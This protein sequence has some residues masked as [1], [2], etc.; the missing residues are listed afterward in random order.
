VLLV[1]AGAA[2][3]ASARF[4]RLSVEDGLSQ[5]S[6]ESIAEDRYGFLWFGTQEGLNRF[7]GHEFTVHQASAAGGHLHDGFIRAIV[8]DSR[9][10]LW[11]GT[12]SGLQ[13]LD[14][15]AGRF[16]ESVTPPGVGVRLNTLRVT[17]TGRLWFAGLNGGLWTHSP[18]AGARAQ[19]VATDVAGRSDLVTA[20]AF[21]GPGFLW[22]ATDGKL[23]SLAIDNDRGRGVE[24]TVL[25]RDIGFVRALHAEPDGV[26]WMGRQGRPPLRFDPR[27]GSATEYPELPRHVLAILPAAEGRLWLGGK[28]AGL[29]RFDPKTREIV[30]YR[31]DPGTEDSLAENDVAVLHQD[32][33]G[34]LW[35]GAWN[36][37][38]SRLNLYAQAFRTLRNTPGQPDSLPDDDVTQMVEAPD[39]RLWTLTRNDVLAVGDP[40]T[41]SFA[42]IPFAGD[43]T[44]I[45]VA[46]AKLFVG[47]TTGLHELDPVSGRTVPSGAALRGAG[48]D[49]MPIESLEGGDGALWIVSEGALYRLGAD[50]ALVRAALPW[51]GEPT[52]LFAPSADRLWIAYAEGVLLRVD[53]SPGDG[54]AVRRVGDGTL[55]SRGR[56]IAVT[57]DRGVVWLGAARGIGR[58][59]SDSRAS[60]ADLKEGMPS[61]SVASILPDA[62]GVLWIPTNLGITRFEPSTGR[63]VHFGAVQGTQA[64][65]YVDEGAARGRSGR[66]YA[67][68]RGLTVFDPRDV[69]DNP[70]RPQVRFT[71][72]EILHRPVLPSWLDPRSPLPTGIHAASEVTLGPQDAVFSVHMA[73]PGVSDP[74]RVRFAHRL[75][76]FDDGW[77]ETTADRRVAT[78]TRLAPGR[79]LLRARARTQNGLWSEE[80][81]TLRIRIL[82]PWWRTPPAMAAWALLALLVITAIISETRRRT[83]VRI[84]LAEQ[85]GLRRASVTDPL[86]G[87]YNRRFLTTWL[88]HELPRTLRTHRSTS[89]D[90]RREFLLVVMADLDNLKEIN[91][92]AGHDAGDRAICLV[93]DLLQSHAR[94]DDLAIRWGGDEFLLILRSVGQSQASQVVERLRASAENLDPGADAD[95]PRCT[96]SLGFASFPFL[97]HDVEGLT[98]EH[99][100]HLADRALLHSKRHARNAWKGFV[101][102][103]E[104]TAAA[105]L[106][107][108]ESSTDRLPSAAIRIVEGP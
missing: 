56:L 26:V 97:P 58:L 74:D 55:A 24:A 48:L 38:L 33:G 8:P 7:D 45:A 44:S 87:L 94:A 61:R 21:G 41:G 67:A 15:A 31:H 49:R 20:V 29:T 16:G 3:A 59:T 84:A 50:G 53:R 37:G 104:T 99:T 10:D 92:A 18:N 11:I 106:A 105:V 73:T 52:S 19:P 13:H 66:F 65:G 4:S 6:V 102:T 51:K 89:P 62:A 98:W 79:Y 36:G 91:D 76:G 34:S 2:H 57:E 100:L 71:A 107:D 96:I 95:T 9:G 83:R 101:S 40:T 68:G 30:N 54:L 90:A 82:P 93:A 60:W 80:E 69:R 70:H 64:S 72:L 25:L 47:T 39:G 78:Y 43:L 5:S 28:D 12:E 81:A 23:I 108:L 85:E 42:T 77:I 88:K 35:V 46:G 22:L 75:D 27:S 1:A 14:V 32:R 17:E 86:T 103:P 63:A